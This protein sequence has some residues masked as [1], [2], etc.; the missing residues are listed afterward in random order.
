MCY[1]CADTNCLFI[2]ISLHVI[3][4]NLCL[5][6]FA[7]VYLFITRFCTSYQASPLFCI[8]FL[9]A[10]MIFLLHITPLTSLHF[11]Q[12]ADILIW[13]YTS[14]F[15]FPLL[16]WPRQ[17][18]E[19]SP[20]VRLSFHIRICPLLSPIHHIQFQSWHSSLP[21]ERNI[22][23]SFISSTPF[24]ALYRTVQSRRLCNLSKWLWFESCYHHSCNHWVISQQCC[25]SSFSE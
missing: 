1:Y 4:H 18:P 3:P 20:L 10:V 2:T 14:I 9:I 23:F 17:T 25:S 24:P 15:P 6:C 5:L 16:L 8:L 11:V 13:T 7:C 19:A 21:Y 22:F 12:P